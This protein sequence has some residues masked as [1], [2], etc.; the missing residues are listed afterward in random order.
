MSAL[1]PLS[2]AESAS[3]AR[4]IDGVSTLEWILTLKC[5]HR[6]KSDSAALAMR[7]IKLLKS[8]IV[9]VREGG[10]STVDIKSTNRLVDIDNSGRN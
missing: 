8:H 9:N 10:K 2:L 5:R 7:K 1:H 3:V 4:E 6:N